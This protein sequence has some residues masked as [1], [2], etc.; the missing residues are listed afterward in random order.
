ML[1]EDKDKRKTSKEI[2]EMIKA[3]Y[4]KKYEKHSSFDSIARCLYSFTPLT[5]NFLNIPSFQYI[6][7][8][9]TK[10]YI[11]CLRSVR[12]PS[13]LVWVNSI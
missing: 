2:L 4:S 13:L 8:P 5:N 12:E 1:E 10:V 9:I 11:E 3:E 6:N 7:K